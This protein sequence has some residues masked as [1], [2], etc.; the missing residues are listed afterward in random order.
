MLLENI[1]RELVPD[2]NKPDE[3]HLGGGFRRKRRRTRKTMK[4]RKSRKS[5]KT[6]KSRKR[7]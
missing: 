1:D 2:Y 6:R 5:R 7:F 3:P 4:T